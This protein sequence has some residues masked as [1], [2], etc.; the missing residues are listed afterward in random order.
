MLMVVVNNENMG[1]LQMNDQEIIV[2]GIDGRYPKMTKH[3]LDEGNLSNIE[4][5][6]KVGAAS[7][8]LYMQGGN[9]TIYTANEDNFQ[10]VHI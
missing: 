9:P 1:V 8:N 3:L 6:F 5:M 4:K 7:E 2:L 10:Q